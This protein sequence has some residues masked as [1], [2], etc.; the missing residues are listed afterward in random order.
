MQGL[1]GKT[2][3][4]LANENLRE[5]GACV[6][7]GRDAGWLAASSRIPRLYELALARAPWKLV[8]DGGRSGTGGSGEK[9]GEGGEK[10]GE[11]G[12][13]GGGGE[14]KRGGCEVKGG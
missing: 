1:S 7:T 8:D 6:C 2:D 4:D 13:K 9:G 3:L 14:E 10:R 11:G 5:Q 12:E